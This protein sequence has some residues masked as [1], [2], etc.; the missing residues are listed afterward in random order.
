VETLDFGDPNQALLYALAITVFG[1]LLGAIGYAIAANRG[2]RRAGLSIAAALVLA[3]AAIAWAIFFTPF[4]AVEVRP[5]AISLRKVYPSRVVTLAREQIER[6]ERRN[7]VTKNDYTVV[8][9]V[10]AKDGKTYTSGT[11]RPQQ[12]ADQTARLQAWLSTP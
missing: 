6:F 3:A 1:G 2:A 11:T 12:L 8:L 10:H 7:E 4:Y 9:V 5:D